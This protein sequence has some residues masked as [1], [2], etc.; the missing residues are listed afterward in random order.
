[1]A[2]FDT[3]D[4]DGFVRPAYGEPENGRGAWT[5]EGI[6]F[7]YRYAMADEPSQRI[8]TRAEV[9]LDH[10][11]VAA[12][13][14]AIQRRL[15]ELGNMDPVGPNEKGIYG[16]RTRQAVRAFQADNE[17]PDGGARLHVD[18]IVGRSDA[19]ALFTPMITAAEKRHDIPRRLLLGETNHE[20]M[21]DPGA[22]G[23][24]IYYPDYR[25]VDR[26][27]SQINAKANPQVSWH[28]AYDPR[29]ALDW[30]ARR[31]RSYFDGFRQR[32]PKTGTLA[33]W[34]AAVCAHNNPSAA[35][36]WA[37]DGHPPT[38][39]AAKYVSGVKHARY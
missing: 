26:A 21:L 17:D 24:F 35:W 18:G 34:D 28:E 31:M 20:S 16:S 32:Y 6:D 30:S 15:V 25:G 11:S 33:L 5:R 36:Q 14:Y 23:Y 19:R 7:D 37:R 2:T 12:G 29:F 9:S 3:V 39:A 22:V 27:M 38:E 4:P 8:G 10:W 1:M 13:S